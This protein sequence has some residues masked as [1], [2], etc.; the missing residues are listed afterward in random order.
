M[1]RI[2][3]LLLRPVLCASVM[4]LTACVS[5]S[6]PRFLQVPSDRDW[7]PTLDRARALADGGQV[8][9]ADSVLAQFTTTYPAAPQ[10]IEANYW[11]ALLELRSPAAS[12]AMSRVIPLLQPYVA[13]GPST[14]HWTEADALLRA[15][16]RVDTLSRVAATY[17]SRG[18]VATD[19]ANTGA[20]CA[21]DP[22]HQHFTR[23][24]LVQQC[25]LDEGDPQISQRVYVGL[26]Q[27][28]RRS[29]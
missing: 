23:L 22:K 2:R 10:A 16:S 24:V 14:E 11:R 27:A 8:E 5:V 7:K 21:G 18:E 20:P 12:Q 13:A 3:T 28:L 9:R 17:I 1:I 6:P 4:S 26:A 19:A 25:R 15:V 29:G